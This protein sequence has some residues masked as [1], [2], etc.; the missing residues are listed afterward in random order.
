MKALV[1]SNLSLELRHIEKP[2]C[3]KEEGEALIRVRRA[4][5]CGTDLSI[6]SGHYRNK[7]EKPLVLGHEIFGEVY[8]LEFA[9]GSERLR[10]GSRVVPEINISCG[11]CS[12]CLAGLGIHCEKIETLGIDRDGGF[13]EFVPVPERNLHVIP[14]SISDDEAVFVEPLA[15]AIELTKMGK[16]GEERSRSASFAVLGAGR[17]GLLI[18][19]V[20]KLLEPKCLAAFNRTSGRKL[21]L[22]LRFGA[23]HAFT[24]EES[25][26]AKERLTFGVGF[27][28]VVEATGSP[29]GLSLAMSLV[30]P[31][32]TIHVKSTHGQLV[33]F[34]LTGAVVKEIAIQGSRC[35][36]FDEAI[37]LI[38]RGKVTTREL[39]S[40]RFPLEKF[41][42]AFAI[43]RESSAIKVLLE[44]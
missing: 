5:I 40:H 39:I 6:A 10:I 38:A 30:R 18:I 21:D 8:S 36:P 33:E 15:A 29:E 14:D 19:Q 37:E 12:T 25:K 23:S 26:T 28:H 24:L 27:D 16:M 41:E 1:Y 2:N 34:D 35:G 9:K 32:G 11:T 7:T 31:R 17:L 22:A 20:L 44:P 4:G 3:K 43:A 42:E 13:A